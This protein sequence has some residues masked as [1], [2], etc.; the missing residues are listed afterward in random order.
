MRISI[1]DAD[2]IVRTDD[3]LS[4]TSGKLYISNASGVLVFSVSGTITNNT[5]WIQVPLTWV[6]GNMP[7]DTA[8]VY[9]LNVPTSGGGS[10]DMVSFFLMGA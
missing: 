7:S 9:I 10:S 6:S 8:K 3:I 5:T 1:N 4:W 2:T